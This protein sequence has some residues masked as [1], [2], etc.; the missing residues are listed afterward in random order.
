MALGAQK[1][2]DGG[3]VDSSGHGY[4]DGLGSGHCGDS[5]YFRI[6]WS[7]RRRRPLPGEGINFGE[8]MGRAFSPGSFGG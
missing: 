3:G 6:F 7:F 1:C 4:G 5:F 2:G 8:T